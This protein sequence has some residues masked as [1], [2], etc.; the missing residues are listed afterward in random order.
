LKQ[1]GYYYFQ[2]SLTTPACTEGVNWI[3]ANRILAATEE[4]IKLFQFTL[5]DNH[6]Y[7]PT[8]TIT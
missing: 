2:G 1:D 5:L 4:E 7:T 6:R 8:N 3:V